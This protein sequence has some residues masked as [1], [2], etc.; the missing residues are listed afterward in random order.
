MPH[1]Y[2]ERY[3]MLPALRVQGSSEMWLKIKGV[4]L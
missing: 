1:K 3:T 4:K 2:Q